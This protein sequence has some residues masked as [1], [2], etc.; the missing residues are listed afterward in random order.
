METKYHPGWDL[1][2]FR[3]PVPFDSSLF[4]QLAVRR[5]RKGTHNKKHVHVDAHEV[6]LNLAHI[7]TANPCSGVVDLNYILHY[8]K[9]KT[10]PLHIHDPEEN[11]NPLIS[12][13]MNK[14]N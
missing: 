5:K 13:L 14:F 12:K 10:N 2:E 11:V 4:H 6:R 9:M 8:N 3:Q 1:S 7:E